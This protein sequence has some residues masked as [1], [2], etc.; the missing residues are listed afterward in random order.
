MKGGGNFCNSFSAG[1]SDS[2]LSPVRVDL[3]RAIRRT[4]LFNEPPPLLPRPEGLSVFARQIY[5]SIKSESKAENLLAPSPLFLSPLPSR[6]SKPREVRAN[7]SPLSDLA[8]VRVNLRVTK[9][10]N[11]KRA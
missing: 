4:G 5:G 1:G 10:T 8:F 6:V 2:T 3:A 9:F 7:E 11:P